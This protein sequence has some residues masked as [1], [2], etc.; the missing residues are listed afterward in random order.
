MGLILLANVT[1]I[2]PLK[3]ESFDSPQVTLSALSGRSTL[4]GEV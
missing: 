3:I 4:Q 1:V 2:D